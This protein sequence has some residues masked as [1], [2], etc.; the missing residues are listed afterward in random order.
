MRTYTLKPTG[1]TDGYQKEIK[2]ATCM[3]AGEMGTYCANCGVLLS[4][5]VIE[6]LGHDYGEWTPNGDK[7]HSHSCSRCQF[8]DKATCKFNATV[9]NP[10]CTE[11]GYTTYVCTD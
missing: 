8:T 10:T 11:G 1:H 5:A 4:M 6:A 7:T 9:T 3:T 2:A